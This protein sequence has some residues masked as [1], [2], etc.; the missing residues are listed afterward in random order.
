MVGCSAVGCHNSTNDG[1]IL[2]S[3]PRDPVRRRLWA[4]QVGRKD[5]KPTN[6]TRICEVHFEPQMWERTREDGKRILKS[7]AY[8]T[9]FA[10]NNY[11]KEDT[12]LN[13]DPLNYNDSLV[14]EQ[15]P[16]TSSELKISKEIEKSLSVQI[17]Q[18][19][20][21]SSVLKAQ[22][23]PKNYKKITT[24]YKS[25]NKTSKDDSVTNVIMEDNDQK[26]IDPLADLVEENKELYKMSNVITNLNSQISQATQEIEKLKK[27]LNEMSV[28]TVAGQV[29]MSNKKIQAAVYKVD[30]VL[31]V[32][33]NGDFVCSTKK[34]SSDDQVAE[35]IKIIA[36]DDEDG[37]ENDDNESS[38]CETGSSDESEMD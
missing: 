4:D 35:E 37:G 5:W 30:D 19:S 15:Q 12:S 38:C 23:T 18:Q 28:R 25:K 27:I 14:I 9:L 10:Y 16:S 29:L 7:D 8:P 20:S 1:F 22:K 11:G 36:Y 6:C 21:S 17:R 2:K 31:S 26:Q 32:Y 13:K 33:V 34:D 24:S 3:F